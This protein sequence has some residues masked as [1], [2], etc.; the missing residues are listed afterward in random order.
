MG[1]ETGSDCGGPRT[2]TG[3]RVAPTIRVFE[4]EGQALTRGSL[5]VVPI[6][7]RWELGIS[8]GEAQFGVAYTTV[9]RIH[10]TG[11]GGIG[12]VAVRDATMLAR[13]GAIALIAGLWLWR[14]IDGLQRSRDREL[15]RRW[16]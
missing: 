1:A 12:S 16:L 4:T 8:F 9:N 15:G 13:I 14:E 10:L 6:A 11:P 7:K 2:M 3:P 5:T